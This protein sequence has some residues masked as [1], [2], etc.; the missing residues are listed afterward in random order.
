MQRKKLLIAVLALVLC[1]GVASAALLP[2][3]GEITTDINVTQ[4]ILVDGKGYDEM[5]IT[6][7]LNGVGG[8]L[9]TGS[10]HWLRSNADDKIT[11]NIIPT[12]ESSPDCPEGIEI[13]P[14]YKLDAT[15]DDDVLFVALGSAITWADFTG[16]SFSYLIEVDLSEKAWI[17]QITLVLRDSEGVG[18]YYAAWHSNSPRKIFGVVGERVSI[19]YLKDD[20]LIYMLPS[21]EV[22]GLYGDD[23][24]YTWAPEPRL[25]TPEEEAAIKNELLTLQFGYFVQQAGCT[26][27]DTNDQ[28]I[29]TCDP[30]LGAQIRSQVVWVSNHAVPGRTVIGVKV[31]PSSYGGVL[32]TLEFRMVYK[33]HVLAIP[34]LYTITT[35]VQPV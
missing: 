2:Y 8:N 7:T 13:Y 23:W 18:K 14:E 34:G 20:F 25:I 33:F 29:C 17:P 15:V 5:P 10:K 32:A 16:I 26:T 30:A 21:W 31:L 4:S 24:E 35:K 3:F 28:Q 1:V 12:L 27:H 11:V 9:I 22:L 19:T 6:E